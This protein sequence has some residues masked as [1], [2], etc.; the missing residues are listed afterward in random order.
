MDTIW[1][2]YFT[3]YLEQLFERIFP[4]IIFLK[5][6]CT[7][8]TTM[9]TVLRGFWM[10][11]LRN[12]KQNSLCS[13]GATEH[14]KE[15]SHF[16]STLAPLNYSNTWVGLFCI[17]KNKS[18]QTGKW[19]YSHKPLVLEFY[20]RQYKL[21]TDLFLNKIFNENFQKAE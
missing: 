3:C 14:C 17:L 12:L 10:Y 13:R 2:L 16:F 15:S 18:L 19:K 20:L 1:L 4:K 9:V 11:L 21:I 8:C 7:T 5:I 6:H